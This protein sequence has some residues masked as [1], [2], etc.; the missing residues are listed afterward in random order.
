MIGSEAKQYGRKRHIASRDSSISE[1]R[2][3][4][5][6]NLIFK[7]D[8]ARNESIERNA[9]TAKLSVKQ[10]MAIL[11]AIKIKMDAVK[12]LRGVVLDKIIIR[13][14]TGGHQRLVRTSDSLL[15]REK[16]VN[17]LF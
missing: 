4:C 12:K 13:M 5:R 10:R 3:G 9:V 11:R 6:I 17:S 8:F 7:F 15:N 2:S 14:N 16:D 1:T